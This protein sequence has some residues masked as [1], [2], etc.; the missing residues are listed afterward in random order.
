[1]KKYNS[2]EKNDLIKMD[3]SKILRKTRTEQTNLF[4]TIQY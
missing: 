2:K 4:H 1:M 3:S